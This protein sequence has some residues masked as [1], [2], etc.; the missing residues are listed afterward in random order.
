MWA[1]V[2]RPETARL[3]Q[4]FQVMLAESEE[5]SEAWVGGS[6]MGWD[7]ERQPERLTGIESRRALGVTMRRL[8]CVLKE[9]LVHGPK[10]IRVALVKNKASKM[11]VIFASLFFFFWL[12]FHMYSCSGEIICASAAYRRLVPSIN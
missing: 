2:W 5:V 1:M 6:G 12:G 7:T 10:E 3:F 8:E 4:Q 11:C 9:A